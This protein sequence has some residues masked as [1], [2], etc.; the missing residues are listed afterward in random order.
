[1]IF[2]HHKNPVNQESLRHL[3]CTLKTRAMYIENACKMQNYLL[4][5]AVFPETALSTKFSPNV[6]HIYIFLY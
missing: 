3:Y 5:L 6:L 4:D 1:M 2:S